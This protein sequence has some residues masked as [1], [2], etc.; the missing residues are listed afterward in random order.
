MGER[1]HYTNRTLVGNWYEDRLDSSKAPLPELERT[2]KYRET[3][4][5]MNRPVNDMYTST[6]AAEHG[7]KVQPV[8]PEPIAFVSRE[9]LQNAM[10]TR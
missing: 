8:E 2:G 7:K 6:N 4:L 10:H 9:T 5:K 3:P 1:L